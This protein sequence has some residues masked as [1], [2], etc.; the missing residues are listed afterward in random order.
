MLRRCVLSGRLFDARR[1]THVAAS[2]P[3]VAA[4]GAVRSAST[5]NTPPP[6]EQPEAKTASDS[7][8]P[9][10]VSK[11]TSTSA[12]KENEPSPPPS[13][14]STPPEGAEAQRG[15]SEESAAVSKTK[16]TSDELSKDETQRWV[17][18]EPDHRLQDE[19]GDWIVSKVKW[20]TGELAYTTPPPPNHLQARFGYNI[21]QVKKKQTFWQYYRW[22]P[23]V[24]FR[25]LNILIWFAMGLIMLCTYL[26]EEINYWTAESKKPGQLAGEVRGK[27][28]P[29]GRQ[30]Q[31]TVS[32]A[33]LDE[34]MA[35]MQKSYFDVE[36]L[37]YK[38]SKEYMMKKIPRPKEFRV[39]DYMRA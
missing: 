35:G 10:A 14:S 9:E 27:G 6:E 36:E 7:A 13:S 17:Q 22:N 21:V 38:G 23:F 15:S 11:S 20:H 29:V 26:I 18:A 24:S 12:A 25:H 8:A 33:E 31:T 5:T 1:V 16:S 32:N 4:G 34:H 3:S 19:K 2:T 37:T 30:L 28:R 39:Q